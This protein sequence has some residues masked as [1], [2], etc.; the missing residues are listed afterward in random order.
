MRLHGVYAL[1]DVCDAENICTHVNMHACVYVCAYLPS[2]NM[3]H[4]PGQTKSTHVMR[5]MYMYTIF[6]A[7]HKRSYVMDSHIILNGL[8]KLRGMLYV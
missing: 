7:I 8:H 4:T 6:D 2:I 5:I 1:G 3:I